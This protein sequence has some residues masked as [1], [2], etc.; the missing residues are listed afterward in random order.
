[1]SLAVHEADAFINGIGMS[2]LSAPPTPGV[3]ATLEFPGFAFSK[4][5]VLKRMELE[6][7]GL[8]DLFH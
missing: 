2:V 8:G 5:R 3:A 1:L 7:K 4:E 6:L